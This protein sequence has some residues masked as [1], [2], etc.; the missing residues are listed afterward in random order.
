MILYMRS[1][2]PKKYIYSMYVGADGMKNGQHFPVN[3][4]VFPREMLGLKQSVHNSMS[5]STTNTLH[6]PSEYCYTTATCIPV[7][8]NDW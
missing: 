8:D 4:I 6:E 5:H 7:T 2:S 1:V 3:I